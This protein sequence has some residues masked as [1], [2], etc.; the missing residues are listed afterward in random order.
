MEPLLDMGYCLTTDNFYTSP[1]LADFLIKRKTDL[2][3]TRR[4]NRLDVPAEIRN[5][6]LKKGEITAF[7]RGK[8]MLLKWKDKKDVCLLGVDRLDQQLHDYPIARKRGKKYYKKVFF[9]FL[10]ISLWNSFVL[11]KKNGGRRDNLECRQTLIEKLIEKFHSTSKKGRP[12][13]QPGPL[14]LTERHFPEYVPPTEKKAAPCRYCAVCCSKRDEKG[15]KKRKETRYYCRNC[16][17][18]LCAVPCFMIYH[19]KSNF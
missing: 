15:K 11:Y 14:R 5:K 19:T 13:S 10:D 17:V 8:V 9:H 12:S 2:Y 7:Q 16:D 1:R 6:K 4:M 3:G 18:G